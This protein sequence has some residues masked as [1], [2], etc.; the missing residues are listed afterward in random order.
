MMAVRIFGVQPFC[1]SRAD[2]AI[3]CR[4]E[5]E[6]WQSDDGQYV[7]G[8]QRA[9]KLQGII[10]AQ[11]MLLCQIEAALNGRPLGGDQVIAL[12]AVI[13][14]HAQVVTPLFVGDLAPMIASRKR[15]AYLHQRQLRDKDRVGGILKEF[16]HPRAAVSVT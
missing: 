10:A 12:S 5:R 4:H 6:R 11:K 3:V 7:V 1:D 16:A 9:G 15:A 13:H 2:Q 8:C 14:K